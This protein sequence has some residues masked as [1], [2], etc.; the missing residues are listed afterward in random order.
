MGL[1]DSF[2]TSLPTYTALASILATLSC[3]DL[4]E[5]SWDEVARAPAP[6]TA[7]DAV[8]IETNGGATTSFGYIVYVVPRGQPAE[9]NDTQSVARLY[10]AWR[11]ASAY[12]VSLIWQDST[13][14]SLDYLRVRDAELQDSVV[15]V[16]G[17]VISVSLRAGI[18]D[19]TAPSGGMLWN[20]QGRPR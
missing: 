5:P 20:R 12:G 11:S 17:H 18:T 4:G 2:K 19:S 7:V 16:D 1:L 3:L 14:L 10:G 13:H 9:R 8:L 15:T 6:S